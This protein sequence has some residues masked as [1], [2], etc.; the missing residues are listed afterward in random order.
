MDVFSDNQLME[1]VRD[2][3]VEKMAILFERY[4]MMLFNF[5]L[6]LT[7]NKNISEDL[8]QDVFYR[9]LRYRHT[10]KGKNRFTIWM[11][12]IARNVHIDYLR[13]NKKAVP[14]EDQWEE[15]H[16]REPAPTEYMEK[17]KDIQLV[18][19]AMSRL[20]VKKREILILSRFQDL[21]YKEIAELMDCH[22]GTVKATVHRAIKDLGKIYGELSGGITS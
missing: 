6:R 18:R 2:G 11:Y 16:S 20:S 13:K 10:Y 12:Q 9:M 8:V 4:H 3:K 15:I 5:M 21:K 17:E 1:Q 14:L 22:I 19:L 7:G